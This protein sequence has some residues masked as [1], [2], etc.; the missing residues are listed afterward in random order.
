MAIEPHHGYFR[1]KDEPARSF[2]SSSLLSGVGALVGSLNQLGCRLFCVFSAGA[3]VA[4]LPL[5]PPHLPRYIGSSIQRH[6]HLLPTV[7]QEPQTPLAAPV[8]GLPWS[9]IRLRT[10]SASKSAARRRGAVNARHDGARGAHD[11]PYLTSAAVPQRRGG[12][13]TRQSLREPTGP[14]LGLGERAR[15]LRRGA[16]AGAAWGCV[17]L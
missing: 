10:S 13:K 8:R 5:P 4:L 3:R 16:G 1:R 11:A 17:A 14:A 9:R 12:A 7:A 2:C 6:R 15:R